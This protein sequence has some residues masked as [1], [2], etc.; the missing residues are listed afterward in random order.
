MTTWGFELRTSYIKCSYQTYWAIGE[1]DKCIACKR[2]KVQTIV[3]S[4]E[5]VILKKSRK[6]LTIAFVFFSFCPSQRSFSID[7]QIFFG[8]WL[9]THEARDQDCTYSLVHLQMFLSLFP[10][11]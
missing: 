10:L 5:N 3:Q 6:S 8:S 9:V 11:L 7:W 2:L 4:L 1:I